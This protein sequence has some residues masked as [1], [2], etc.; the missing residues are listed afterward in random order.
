MLDVEA[1]KQKE[2]LAWDACAGDYDS[3][4][5]QRFAAFSRTLVDLVAPRRGQ[6]VLDVATGSGLAALMAAELVGPEGK[7]IGVDLSE[8]MIE[9]ARNRAA[10][11]GVGNVRFLPMD[12]ERLDLPDESFDTALCA[13]GLMLFPQPDVA[14]S[15]MFRV[16]KA[17]GIA[18][19]SVFGRGSKVALRAL[20][21]PF[22]PH[23]PPPPQQGPR[24]FGFG[25]TEVLA[26]A[27][28]RAGFAEVAA[29]TQAHV[30]QFESL[31]EVWD[32]PRSLGRLAQMSSALPAEAGQELRQE[33][34]NIAREKYSSPR[35]LYELP[36]EVTY[37]VGRKPA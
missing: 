11:Q 18:G 19:I 21:E 2:Q 36:F 23:M 24:T 12:A 4:L 9:L 28:E 6:R 22:L 31:E 1:F 14:L 13:L 15:E 20:M 35:G 10:Q 3:C 29:Q 17:G 25:R 7:A 33:V 16:L 8:T 26:Q 32:L 27:L 5:T 37:A 30:L 34:L